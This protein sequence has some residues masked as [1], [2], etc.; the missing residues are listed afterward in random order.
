MEN[1]SWYKFC[2][3]D[4]SMGKIQRCSREARADYI[5]ICCIYWNKEGGVYR[6]DVEGVYDGL[7]ELLTRKVLTFTDNKVCIKFL[8]E[9]LESIAELREKRAKAGRK[10]GKQRQANAKQVLD[11]SKQNQAEE[12]REEERRE[13]EKIFTTTEEG[14]LPVEWKERV[15]HESITG[16]PSWLSF[17]KQYNASRGRR[18]H[19]DTVKAFAD[20]FIGQNYD[21][22]KDYKEWCSHFGFWLK[23]KDLPNIERVAL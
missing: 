20:E 18:T 2:P 14:I 4:W 17:T 6:D 15:P 22:R 11:K 16:S 1:L 7:D 13:D 8:D 9:Q 12:S 3:A 19:S 5:D 21:V 23:K 10:G